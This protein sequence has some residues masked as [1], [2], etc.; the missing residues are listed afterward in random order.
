MREE[1]E[2]VEI[3]G[4]L[5]ESEILET[6]LIHA[7]EFNRGI[8]STKEEVDKVVKALSLTATGSLREA[9]RARDQREGAVSSERKIA[10][11]RRKDRQL[12]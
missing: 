9:R 12:S 7:V 2:P 10:S 4:F 1:D 11:G 5:I 3:L 6:W 8:T